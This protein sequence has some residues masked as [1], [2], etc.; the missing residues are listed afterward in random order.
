MHHAMLMCMGDAD[1]CQVC[2]AC[3]FPCVSC[4]NLSCVGQSLQRHNKQ[5]EHFYADLSK[6]NVA[7]CNS[8]SFA[9]VQVS[10]CAFAIVMLKEN[11]LR[12]HDKKSNKVH[13]D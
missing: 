3:T 1:G 6:G 13:Y 5:F 9:T 8:S 12:M 2:G 7:V 4:L 11:E 10:I